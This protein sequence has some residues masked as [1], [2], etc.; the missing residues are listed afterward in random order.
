[1][2]PEP[3]NKE[4]L[5]EMMRELSAMYEALMYIQFSP[6]FPISWRVEKM[7][8]LQGAFKDIQEKLEFI[9]ENERRQREEKKRN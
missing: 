4:Q 8:Q 9:E 6:F 1:M 7:E 2:E 3:L 5:L